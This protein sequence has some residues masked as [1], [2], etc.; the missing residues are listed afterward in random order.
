VGAGPAGARA[1]WVL[2]RH[3]A[4]VTI[5]DASHP[6]EKPCGGGVTGRALALVS[7]AIDATSCAR[8]PIHTARFV[9]L[10]ASGAS[11]GQVRVGASGASA[12]QAPD[13]T[14]LTSRE[15]ATVDLDRG[16]LVV[17][18]RAEFDAALLH[19]AQQAGAT[20]ESARVT[21][22][23][24][25][26]DGVTLETRHGHRRADVVIGADGANSL[27]RRRVA[28][29]F[30]RDQLSIATGFFAHG[31]TSTEIV[32]ALVA[33]PPGY[34][35]SFPRPGH[36]AIGICAEATVGHSSEALRARTA[37]WI[38]ATGIAPGARLEP[39]AWPIPSLAV[40]D[41]HELTVAGS[42]W[43]LAGDAAGLVDPI[44]REGI[45]FALASGQWAAESLLRDGFASAYSSRVAE[46]A[47][48][49]LGR[50]ARFKAGFFRPAFINV[51]M[52]ALQQSAGVRAVM[53]DLIAG[54]Q[55]YADLK[56]RLLK[57]FEI[58]LAWRALTS[59]SSRPAL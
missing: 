43:L 16:A 19:A 3:G 57:T 14:G 20:L 37:E 59:S 29:P 13:R 48:H 17:A 36:L 50:A 55:G 38:R 10:R 35:W 4:R 2:A 5:F 18:S 39:Y 42:R 45:Y 54:R 7:D 41:A 46:E 25:D 1:A 52:L 30:R 12:G 51:L 27:V 53:A 21:D 40:R 15:S 26:A 49:E 31:V 8:T 34:I 11:A 32:I 47:G 6:R 23:R 28:Q 33:D 56:W 22:L 24:I 58:G 44:T 9:R